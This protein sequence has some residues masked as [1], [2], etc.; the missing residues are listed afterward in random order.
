MRRTLAVHAPFDTHQDDRRY[1]STLA[2]S[3]SGCRRLPDALTI[4]PMN[5]L[6]AAWLRLK[7]D[8]SGVAAA[9]QWRSALAAAL[10]V[11]VTAWV[12]WQVPGTPPFVVA[13]I[14]ASAVILFVLPGSPFAQPWAVVGG[15]LVAAAAGVLAAS[16]VPGVVPALALAIG[17]TI[18]GM[19]ALRCLHPP[20]GAVALY[21]VLGGEPVRALGWQFLLTPVLVNALLLVAV[22]LLVNNLLPGRRYPRPP[23]T[24]VP[25][26]REA[27]PLDRTGLRR[28]DLQAALRG[29]GHLVDVGNEELDEIVALAERH[30]FRRDF[31]ELSCGDIMSRVLVTVRPQATL[32]EAWRRLRQQRLVMLLVVD[33]LERVEGVVA[34]ED[35]VRAAKAETVRG[36]RQ[37]L[38]RLLRLNFARDAT[39]G[40]I[41]RR[42]VLTVAAG[43][44]VAELVAPMSRGI[45]QAAV[46]D[47][48]RRLLG[49][50]TQSD[51]V[52][53][54]YR[55]R[56][57]QPRESPA[58]AAPDSL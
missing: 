30:A 51:L 41:M 45:H 49:V 12:S 1:G 4:P 7:P 23:P 32:L 28:R 6:R 27:E 20:G 8:P 47:A 34:L 40:S 38:F 25:G 55:G 50:V 54:L 24:A 39:V 56:L 14:G 37:R 52:A 31:G 16:W 13:S 36:L 29:Y 11:F 33:A 48:E 2:I 9:E 44:H 17:L 46:V 53:A 5:P 57:L 42:E 43:D 15:Y 18:L 58:S 19:L 10:A 26:K 21:A 22:A 3:I 35:F